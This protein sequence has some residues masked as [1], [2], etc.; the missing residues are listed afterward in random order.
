VQEQFMAPRKPELEFYDT[1]E[2]P[3]EVRNLAGEARH[4]ARI[5]SMSARLDAWFKAAGDTGAVPE[6]PKAAAGK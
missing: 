3:H 6:D 1:A 5:A 4:K 2:D